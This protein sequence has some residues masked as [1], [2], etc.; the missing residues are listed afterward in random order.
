MDFGSGTLKQTCLLAQLAFAQQSGSR[1]SFSPSVKR[2]FSTHIQLKILI[3]LEGMLSHE[4][5]VRNLLKDVQSGPTKTAE[6]PFYEA[7][8]G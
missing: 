6:K 3:E 7:K 2:K 8:Q 4:S 5:P 1:Q